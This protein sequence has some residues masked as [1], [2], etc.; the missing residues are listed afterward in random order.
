MKHSGTHFEDPLA[1]QATGV[2]GLAVG[3]RTEYHD[4][5]PRSL[6]YLVTACLLFLLPIFVGNVVNV[7]EFC[8]FL[9]RYVVEKELSGVF[10]EIEI[11][12]IVS[13][14]ALEAG[15]IRLVRFAR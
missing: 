3:V 13:R 6:L 11:I 15:E 7:V 2:V 1:V 12:L 8:I 14:E 9:L 5:L 10:V 4:A